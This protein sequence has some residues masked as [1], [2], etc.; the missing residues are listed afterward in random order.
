[1]AI[2]SSAPALRSDFGVL[3]LVGSGHFLAHFYVIALP[4]FFP[5]LKA[6]FGTSYAQLGL[7]L[8]VASIAT[9]L[10]QVPVGV[11]VD[12]LGARRILALGCAVMSGAVVLAGLTTRYETLLMVMV[13][14]GVG[15]AVFHPA[16]YAI[17]T[18]RINPARLGRAYSLH[19]FGGHLG[20]AVAPASMAFL[21][22]LWDWRMALV[23]VGLVG[24][25]VALAIF[26]AG[27]V[28]DGNP[29][30]EQDQTAPA[31]MP[32]S[33]V[34]F[35]LAP[36]LLLF[37]LYMVLTA[38]ATSGINSFAVVALIEI[39]AAPLEF[40]NAGLTAFLTASALGVLLG[41]L[42]A[43]KTRRFEL[44]LTFG[45]CLS[46]ALLCL[47]GAAGLPL[48]MV[49]LVLV[50]VGAAQGAIRPSRDM[51][52][53]AIVPAGSVGT[54]FGFVTMGLNVGGA[55]AP[56]LFGWLIDHGHASGLFYGAAAVMLLALVTAL[57]AR[58][59]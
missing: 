21:A 39:Y 16:D 52:V 50:V 25:A 36:P 18:A 14:L 20:W 7:L 23:L 48:V 44:I 42:L 47:L 24:L 35:L 26:A 41:G 53:R 9:G 37:F 13:L 43:D 2:D 11:L 40:A 45:F 27:G 51:M 28:L 15:N 32:A 29:A 49:V 22:A 31:P 58:R 4:P 38:L 6:E 1:M 54:A 12:R 57:A 34:R 30:L 17:M 59:A 33:K 3:G 10:T 19:T 8:T 56:V 5:L 46:A 55:L